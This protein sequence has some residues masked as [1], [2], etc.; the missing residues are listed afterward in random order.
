MGTSLETWI[1]SSPTVS[2][3]AITFNIKSFLI[4][5]QCIPKSQKS[6]HFRRNSLYDEGEYLWPS[7][8][9]TCCVLSI[10]WVFSL[11]ACFPGCWYWEALGPSG[12]ETA[13]PPSIYA[14]PLHLAV[15]SLLSQL[16]QQRQPCIC[17]SKG[18]TAITGPKLFG[19]SLSKALSEIDIFSLWNY[20]AQCLRR[21]QQMPY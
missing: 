6:K 4:R 1:Q 19:L 9:G 2:V 8:A 3:A 17:S 20:P 7:G 16:P 12:W 21:Y 10:I 14:W 13:S 18:T 5:L 15:G 11:E